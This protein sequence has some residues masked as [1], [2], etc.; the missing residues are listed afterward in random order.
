M[1]IKELRKAK[2]CTQAQLSDLLNV[3]QQNISKYETGK[4]EP[5]IRTMIKLADY[6]NVTLDYIFERDFSFAQ[7]EF[8]DAT[9]FSPSSSNEIYEKPKNLFKKNLRK[10]RNLLGLSQKSFAEKL[11]IKPTTYRNYE[12]SDREPNYDTLILIA[13]ELD[14]S[15]ENLLG[16]DFFDNKKIGDS[17]EF[18]EDLRLLCK[19][20]TSLDVVGQATLMERA[21]A[22]HDFQSEKFTISQNNNTLSSKKKS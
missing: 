16:V 8:I 18:T 22:L 9:S 1:R 2:G 10:H 5:D 4:L 6:F 14:V 7:N 15:I 21:K 19:L 13:S 11:G 3:S 12:N 20:Y 17:F